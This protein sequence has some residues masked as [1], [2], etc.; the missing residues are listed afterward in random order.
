MWGIVLKCNDL[1]WEYLKQIARACGNKYNCYGK[2]FEMTRINLIGAIRILIR[3]QGIM[4][5]LKIGAAIGIRG[6]AAACFLMI[7]WR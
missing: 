4:D 5:D 7:L 3:W 6:V 1:P 2:E